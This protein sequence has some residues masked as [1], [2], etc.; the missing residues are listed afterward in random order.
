VTTKEQI[1]NIVCA[2][3]KKLWRIADNGTLVYYQACK[4]AGLKWIDRTPD[5]VTIPSE[6]ATNV[7]PG[8]VVEFVA[9]VGNAPHRIALPTSV[10]ANKSS[11][12]LAGF[13]GFGL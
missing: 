9:M 10:Y 3:T 8:A 7:K 1:P 12:T 11:K 4:S 5:A 2:D 6:W 13:M